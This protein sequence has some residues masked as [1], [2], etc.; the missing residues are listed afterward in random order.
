[1]SDR[2]VPAL[3]ASLGGI[4][5]A[6]LLFVP[7]VA[8]QYRHRGRFGFRRSIAA[9]GF[10]SHSL[11]LITYTLLPLP[12]VRPGFCGE[13]GASGAQ[14]VP[15]QF[16]ADVQKHA[17]SGAASLLGNPAVQQMLF[18]IALFVPLGMFVRVLLNKGV[19]GTVATGFAASLLIEFTQLTGVWFLYPC[20][21]RLFD[22]DDLLANTTGAAFGALLAPLLAL[23]VKDAGSAPATEPQPVTGWRRLL[24]A[25]CDL[26]AVVLSGA[27]LNALFVLV[28]KIWDPSSTTSVL[29]EPANVLVSVLL[30]LVLPSQLGTGGTLGQRAVLLRPA[31]ADGSVPTNAHRFARVLLGTAMYFLLSGLPVLGPLF[32]LVSLIGLWRSTGHRGL[33]GRL[34]GLRIVDERQARY[35]AEA[36]TQLIPR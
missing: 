21:Y 8:V 35:D 5:L 2:L 25:L 24:G 10:A 23:L 12:E 6:F 3:I 11:S 1:M 26:A 17:A 22:V 4:F 19:A 13:E 32:G 9:L 30:C 18:N 34:S 14:L 33:S 28:A 31:L 29:P 7:W 36:P 16:V 20:A 15:F 27:L